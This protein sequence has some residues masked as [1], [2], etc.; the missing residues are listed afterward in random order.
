M[1][2]IIQI[3]F[4]KEVVLR[5]IAIINAKSTKSS[6]YKTNSKSFNQ[7]MF[8]IIEPFKVFYGSF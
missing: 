4:L 8:A 2:E 6:G 7:N 1:V 3:T 5:N